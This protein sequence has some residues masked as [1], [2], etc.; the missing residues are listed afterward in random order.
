MSQFVTSSWGGTRKMPYGFTEHETA[1]RG[2]RKLRPAK[3]FTVKLQM[4]HHL[5][6][7]AAWSLTSGE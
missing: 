4:F 3:N 1:K 7:A 5:C 2:S 6:S